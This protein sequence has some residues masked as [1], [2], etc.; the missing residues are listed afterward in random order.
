ME[1]LKTLTRKDGK[2]Y[3]MKDNKDRF[4]FP[5][6]YMAFEDKLKSKQKFS[7]KFLI[8]TGSRINEARK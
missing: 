5:E 4:L 6:E 2:T 7:V 8:N 3:T 1:H